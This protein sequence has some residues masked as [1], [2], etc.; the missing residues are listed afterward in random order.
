[1][2]DKSDIPGGEDEGRP[3]LVS[4]RRRF[5]TGAAAAGAA[6]VT[7]SGL[8]AGGGLVAGSPALAAAMGT[9]VLTSPTGFMRADALIGN[10]YVK[11]YPELAHRAWIPG[12]GFADLPVPTEPGAFFADGLK[13]LFGVFQRCLCITPQA[14]LNFVG[15]GGHSETTH[16]QGGVG[17]GVGGGQDNLVQQ[18]M[19]VIL[20]P[21]EHISKGISALVGPINV[22]HDDGREVKPSFILPLDTETIL[23]QFIRLVNPLNWPEIII[24]FIKNPLSIFDE[25]LKFFFPVHQQMNFNVNVSVDKFPDLKLINKKAIQVESK[26]LDSFPPKSAPYNS[27][28]PVELVDAKNPNGRPLVV[29][30]KWQPTVDHRKNL[31]PQVPSKAKYPTSVDL[32]LPCSQD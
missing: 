15:L 19:N 1:M 18:V 9:P 27:D 21:G 32:D 14:V 24:N 5:L 6:A 16:M 8:V 25:M 13:R 31:P 4:G 7:G 30:E 17:V 23:H 29:I 12:Y 28:G 20:H 22:E 26:G 11:A 3:E 10:P 2:P